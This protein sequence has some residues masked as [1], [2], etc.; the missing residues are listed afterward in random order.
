MQ[1]VRIEVTQSVIVYHIIYKYIL[2]YNWVVLYMYWMD[3]TI[4]RYEVK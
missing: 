4:I 3:G 1:R 2:L